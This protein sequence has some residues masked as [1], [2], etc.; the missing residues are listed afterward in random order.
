MSDES[1]QHE[2]SLREIAEKTAAD[3]FNHKYESKYEAHLGQFRREKIRLLE[4]GVKRGASLAMWEQYFP[5][6]EIFGLD[7]D[8][9]CRQFETARSRIF[10]GDQAS[11][12]DL[13]SMINGIGAPLDIIIDDGGHTMLQ[14]RTSFEVLFEH[15]RPGGLYI[16][17]DTHTSYREKNGGGEPGKPGTFIAMLKELLDDVHYRVLHKRGV[18]V[19]FSVSEV[20]V[21]PKICFIRKGKQFLG[22][23]P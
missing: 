22:T 19:R 10:I 20:H 1:G 6:A 11:P 15:V 14:Q 21:Y 3:K 8:P 4:I 17:E 2:L 9:A 16:V 12:A 7:I 18:N 13:R 5:H 23:Q